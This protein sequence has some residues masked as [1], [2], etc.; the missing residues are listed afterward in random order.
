M[1]TSNIIK[2]V[3]KGRVSDFSSDEKF[4][5]SKMINGNP[6]GVANFNKPTRKWSVEIYDR[7]FSFTWAHAEAR[8]AG[9]RVEYSKLSPENKLAYDRALAQLI[10]NDSLQTSQLVESISSY[11]TDTIVKH[12]LTRQAGEESLH[13]RSYSVMADEVCDDSDSI[14]LKHLT[15]PGIQRKNDSVEMMYRKVNGTENPTV[16]E[17]QM[18][19]A[20]N[21]ILERLVFPGG[22]VTLWAVSSKMPGSAKMISFIERDETGTHVPLFK[23]IFSAVRREHGLKDE[24]TREIT[25]LIIYMSNEEKVWTKDLGKD[26][27]GFSDKAIDLYVEYLANDVC[28]NLKIPKIFEETDGG[29]LMGIVERYSMLSDVKTKTNQFEAPVGDYAVGGLDDDY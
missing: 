16:H 3:N 24:T 25:E 13:S 21:Q 18:A 2:R 23:N 11:I 6:S 7:M 17:F 10:A 8:I 5:E 28:S 19:L 14:Y 4:N 9:D 22:F 12:C 20:A 26:L 27:L 1:N 15:D 29:P